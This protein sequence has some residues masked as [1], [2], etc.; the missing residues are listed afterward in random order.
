MAQRRKKRKVVSVRNKRPI[1]IDL[2]FFG[3]VAVYICVI[4]YM[5]M[6]SVHIAGYEVNA[7]TLAVNHTYTGLA[8]RQETVYSAET[9][10][11]VSYYAREGERVSGSSLVYTIDEK[12]EINELIQ[13]NAENV[14]LTDENF[15]LIR[16]SIRGYMNDYNDM[17]F[18]AVYDIQS[19]L[20]SSVMDLVNQNML[21]SLENAG[22]DSMFSRVYSGGIGI[23]EYYT[24]GYEDIAIESV[25]EDMLDSSSYEKQNLKKEIVQAGEPVYKLSTSEKW[26]LLVELTE[27]EAADFQQEERKYMQVEFTRD[28]TTAWADFSIVYVGATPC[29]KLDFNNSM[30]RFAD[31]RYVEVKFLVDDETGL[32]IPNT[33]IVEKEFY[34]VPQNFLVEQG[35]DKGF[36]KEVYDENGQASVEFVT[37]T[38]Y[39]ADEEYYYIDPKESDF[40]TGKEKMPIGSY[41]VEPDSQERFQIGMNKSL[42]GVYNINKG[43]TQF[44]QINILYQNE[45]FTLVE[46]GTSYGLT[47]Y[48]HIVLNGEAVDEEQIIY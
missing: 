34:L 16:S 35:E 4:C 27:E 38:L 48:D 43:Y 15:S 29:A 14:D 19:A 12:G 45:E 32:K 10:G 1:N 30:V 40:A 33:A 22:E 21:E 36:M 8:I 46:E 3:A 37:M 9:S 42:Q 18:E 39:Y 24:D 28:H 20:E 2:V 44:R 13:Q 25:T 31:L 6:S 5:G 26:S 17:E 47:I 23:L 7:G 41:L 11:Y